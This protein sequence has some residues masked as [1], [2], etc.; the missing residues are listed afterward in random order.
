M[1]REQHHKI[2]DRL[3]NYLVKHEW[4]TLKVPAS[5]YNEAQAFYGSKELWDML[6]RARKDLKVEF[7]GF[8]PIQD[9]IVHALLDTQSRMKD[10]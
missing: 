5:D 9:A 2:A 8:Y 7:F 3:A 6:S 4:K 1:T 10:W